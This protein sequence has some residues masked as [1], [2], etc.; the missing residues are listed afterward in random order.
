MSKKAQK[1]SSYLKSFSKNASLVCLHELWT[2]VC[3]LL[4][5]L[6]LNRDLISIM[7]PPAKRIKRVCLFKLPILRS[8]WDVKPHL[9]SVLNVPHTDAIEPW[10]CDINRM[11]GSSL[12]RINL[13]L[14]M[15]KLVRII[16]GYCK[17]NHCL[18]ACRSLLI[19]T[20]REGGC[21]LG[22]FMTNKDL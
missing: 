21:Y 17:H 14:L 15:N 9:I 7:A 4:G 2:S 20:K 10:Q 1:H 19:Q 18:V 5:D 12:V 3:A 22:Q 11:L 8:E 16:F 13:F 6:D